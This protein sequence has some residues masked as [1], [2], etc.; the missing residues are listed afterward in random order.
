M[1]VKG[2]TDDLPPGLDE[3]TYR[4]CIWLIKHGLKPSVRACDP[5]LSEQA[6]LPL[7]VAKWL[8]PIDMV[9]RAVENGG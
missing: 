5:G 4:Q 7:M 3:R 9:I 1:L 8:D 2:Q 6:R